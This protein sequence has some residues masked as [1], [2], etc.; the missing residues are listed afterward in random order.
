MSAVSITILF[1][2][3]FLPV[4]QHIQVQFWLGHSLMSCPLTLQ[5]QIQRFYVHWLHHYGLQGSSASFFHVPK[6]QIHI[7]GMTHHSLFNSLVAW[8]L[9][10]LNISWFCQLLWFLPWQEAT[11]PHRRLPIRQWDFPRRSVHNCILLNLNMLVSCLHHDC[12]LQVNALL[13]QIILLRLLLTSASS[14]SSSVS[15]TR[16]GLSSVTISSICIVAHSYCVATLFE[17]N[18][19]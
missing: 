9:V 13:L 17:K 5:G 16:N 1:V 10:S 7:L 4:Y 18:V 14:S 15:L 8:I 3:L 2:L 6:F 19:E 11:C 12:M